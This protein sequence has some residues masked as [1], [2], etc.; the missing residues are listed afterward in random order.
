MRY[1]QSFTT[2]RYTTLPPEYV[3][4]TLLRELAGYGSDI[5]PENGVIL[6]DLEDIKLKLMLGISLM[7]LFLF[8]TLLIFCLAALYKLRKL[9]KMQYDPQ[10]SVNPELAEMSYFH[11][12][13]GVSDT[14]FSKSAESSSFWVRSS[15]ELRRSS[16]RRSKSKNVP[17]MISTASDDTEMYESSNTNEQPYEEPHM[18]SAPY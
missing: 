16:L 14:S 4:Q 11:P 8:L 10:Y 12:L 15:S 2:P 3:A 1:H 5:K 17:D 6:N 9:S 18:N 7:S 13:E